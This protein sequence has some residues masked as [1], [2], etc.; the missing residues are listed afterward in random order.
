[1]FGRP[2]LRRYPSRR[3]ISFLPNTILNDPPGSSLS[4][5]NKE[6]TETPSRRATYHAD[7]FETVEAS[8]PFRP[9]LTRLRLVLITMFAIFFWLFA[10]RAAVTQLIIV[11]FFCCLCQIFLFVTKVAGGRT[12][13]SRVVTWTCT[14]CH[15][16]LLKLRRPTPFTVSFKYL[17]RPTLLGRVQKL[18]TALPSASAPVQISTILTAS[19]HSTSLKRFQQLI[20][21]PPAAIT[22]VRIFQ[23]PTLTRYKNVS[24]DHWRR[25]GCCRRSRVDWPRPGSRR[26]QRYWTGRW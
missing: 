3:L 9:D 25:C 8:I 7:R 20:T 24:C 23:L 26:L 21:P 14:G 19:Y 15:A 2:C 6:H 1:M 16:G 4:L 12:A 18:T 22:Q 13:S 10:N 11:S 5:P 17:I